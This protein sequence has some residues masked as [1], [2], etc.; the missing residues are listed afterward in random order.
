MSRDSNDEQLQAVG[1]AVEASSCLLV[2]TAGSAV[3]LGHL[4]SVGTL[5]VRIYFTILSSFM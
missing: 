3:G 5:S 4:R 1:L 2:L